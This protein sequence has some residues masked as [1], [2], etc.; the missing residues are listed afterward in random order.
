MTKSAEKDFPGKELTF[1]IIGA[2]ME[3]HNSL[4]CG[5]LESVYQEALEIE[6][7]SRH[8]P[9][10]PQILIPVTYKGH[11]LKKEYVAD[12]L[13]F[14]Q[15][16]VEIKAL[17]ILTS[18]EEAQLLNYLKASCLP[19]GLLINFGSESLE[20]KRKIFSSPSPVRSIPKSY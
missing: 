13:V 10:K 5:F 7:T 15:I 17:D 9:F 20:W 11:P 1:Q 18:R 6:F 8:I 2:A 3:V 19:V 16:I 12:F 14:D 4:G